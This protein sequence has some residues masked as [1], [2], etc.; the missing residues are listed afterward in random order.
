MLIETLLLY[1]FT[2]SIFKL[3]SQEEQ[4]SCKIYILYKN[5]YDMYK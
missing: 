1:Y 4:D 5:D 3:A 2:D